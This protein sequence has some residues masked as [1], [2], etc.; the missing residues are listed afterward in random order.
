MTEPGRH[1]SPEQRADR[2]FTDLLQELRVSLTGV[3]ILFSLLLTVP[4]SARFDDISGFQRGVYVTALLLSAA[5]SVVL[6][7]PV[8]YHRI[9]FAKGHK[10]RL[11]VLANRLAIGG[12]ALLLAAVT[13]V[14]LLVTDVVLETPVA[15][16]VSALFGVSTAVLW[17]VPPTRRE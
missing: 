6:T 15:I 13:A 8:A 14:L 10:T 5:A 17:L 11:V 2:N 1:E 3:Q 4:F 9:L 12:L 7:A 16:V